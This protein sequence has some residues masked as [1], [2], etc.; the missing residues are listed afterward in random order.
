MT[1][2]ALARKVMGDSL[3]SATL[4]LAAILAAISLVGGTLAWLIL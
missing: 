3:Q 2:C 4:G 1:G